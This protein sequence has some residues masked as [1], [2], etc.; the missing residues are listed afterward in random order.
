MEFWEG[1]IWHFLVK[2]NHELLYRLK[3][4]VLLRYETSYCFIYVRWGFECSIKTLT[5]NKT[6]LK[7]EIQF[8]SILMAFKTGQMKNCFLSFFKN[9]S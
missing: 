3:E 8:S 2:W 9:E 5:H 4:I 6:I 1:T 7:V